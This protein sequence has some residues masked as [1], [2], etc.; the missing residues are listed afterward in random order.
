MADN[1]DTSKQNESHAPQTGSVPAEHS[2]SEERADDQP[3][4]M[5]IVCFKLMAMGWE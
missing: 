5:S 4:P 1:S 3:M 2:T